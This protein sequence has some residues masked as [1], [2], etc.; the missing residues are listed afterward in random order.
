V[1]SYG[2]LALGVGAAGREETTQNALLAAGAFDAI[3]SYQD[4]IKGIITTYWGGRTIFQAFHPG[5]DIAAPLY[6]PIHAA[7]AGRVTWAGYAAPGQRHY[8]YGLCVII[9]HNAHF[10]TLYAHLDD[11]KYGLQVRVGDIVQQGQVIGYEG[12]TGWTTGPHLHFEIRQDNVQVN[13]LLLIPNP[14]D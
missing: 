10:S 8:S 6:T 14:Q 7:A 2:G 5:I 11:Q 1:L 3:D 4:P 12:L 13:P 9:Q